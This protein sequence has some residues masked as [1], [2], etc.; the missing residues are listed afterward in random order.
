MLKRTSGGHDVYFNLK[1]IGLFRC[2]GMS[3]Y[4]T[5]WLSLYGS[6]QDCG[7]TKP[8]VD[9]FFDALAND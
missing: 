9:A 5:L 6:N 7:T 2:H 8:L 4:L 1:R 3:K